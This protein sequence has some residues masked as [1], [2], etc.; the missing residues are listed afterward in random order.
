MTQTAQDITMDLLKGQCEVINPVAEVIERAQK[1]EELG[2]M[3]NKG[4][5]TD[6]TTS[7]FFAIQEKEVNDIKETY[8]NHVIQSGL[9]DARV[10]KYNVFENYEFRLVISKK[11]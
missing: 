4:S 11:T 3:L 9:A 2:K 10:S 5:A 6:K 1:V 7:A 8:Y